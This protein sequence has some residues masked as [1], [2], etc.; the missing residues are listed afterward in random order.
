MGRGGL[1]SLSIRLILASI[2]LCTLIL[3]T[4]GLV[5]SEVNQRAVTQG[6][7]QRLRLY[8]KVLVADLASLIDG[9]SNEVGNLGEPQFQIPLSGWYW[10]I[11]RLDE[12]KE[13][14][15]IL[16]ASRSLYS[17]RLPNI[18]GPSDP[19]RTADAAEGYIEGPDK[20][21]LRAIEQLI[22]LGDGNRFYITVAGNAVEIDE[23][24]RQFNLSLMITF[25]LLG[26][27][28]VGSTILQVR[29]GLQPLAR[30]REAVT[31]IRRGEAER[32]GERFPQEVAPLA[33]ELDQLIDANREIIERARMQV[34]NLA[35]ALKTPL[36]VLVNEADGDE[37]ALAGKLREQ[38]GIMKQQVQYY[39][40]RARAAARA[41][42]IGTLTDVDTVLAGFMRVFPKIYRDR[43]VEFE[44]SGEQGLRF[45]GERQDLEDMVG[46][47]ID[48]AGKW[49]ARRVSITVGT[50][51]SDPAAAP[52]IE[53]LIDDD[54]PGLPPESRK[55]ATRRGR[56]L[57]ETKPGS[58]LG[59]SI[60]ADLAGLYHG[61]VQL[62]DSPLGGLRARLRLPMV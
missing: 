9:A 6:F 31:A 47:L 26:A 16:R 61:S 51:H 56:R 48:N 24:A 5:L 27:A 52:R 50:F 10:Q 8:M 25:L 21:R 1:R 11:V 42:A 34:G 30:L 44:M 38:A 33:H 7:D 20:R 17:A 4:A 54:G 55:E 28:L 14:F 23:R 36:S 35:H 45:R 41:A 13:T 22:D 49:A 19:A 62:E 59:L 57:D 53:I 58:G 3:L 60:V 37:T 39:L 40:D 29:F 12:E 32:I 43:D 46:N 15:A 18:V 2:V